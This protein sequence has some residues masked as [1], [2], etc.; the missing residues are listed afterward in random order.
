MGLRSLKRPY[1]RDLATLL[2]PVDLLLAKNAS[3]RVDDQC[4][5]CLLLLC[6]SAADGFHRS[7]RVLKKTVCLVLS[8]DQVLFWDDCHEE[9]QKAL[10]LWW[11]AA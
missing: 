6:Y 10:L 9:G 3:Q 7:L 5:S 1:A 2:E 8:Q 4:R 11:H